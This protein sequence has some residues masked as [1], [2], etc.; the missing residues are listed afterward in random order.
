M[1]IAADIASKLNELLTVPHNTEAIKE[2]ETEIRLLHE[3]LDCM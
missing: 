1:Y 3:N 2:N